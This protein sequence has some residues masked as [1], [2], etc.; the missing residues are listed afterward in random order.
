MGWRP[1][2]V[3]DASLRDFLAAVS[4]WMEA[5]GR[6]DAY[7]PPLTPDELGDL[8]EKYPDG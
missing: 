3:R 6:A 7:N 1:S 8:M 4:G 2:E 5:T